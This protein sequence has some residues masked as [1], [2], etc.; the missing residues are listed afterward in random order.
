M[1]IRRITVSR[2]ESGRTVAALLQAHFQLSA[3]EVRRLVQARRVRIGGKVCADPAWR[4]APGQSLKA[5]LDPSPPHA[6]SQTKAARHREEQGTPPTVRH[7][8]DRLVIVDKPAGLTTMRHEYEAEE[9]GPRGRRFLPATLADLLPDLLPKGRQGRAARVI[10][11]HRL[12]RE[13]SG[14][15]AFAR[16]PEAARHLGA[17]FREHT[18][19]RTYLALTRG[20]P[21][22]GRVESRIVRDRGDGRRGSTEKPGEGQRAVTHV[23]VVEELGDFALVECRLETGR[24]HQVRIH[25]G[26][27]GAP[28]CGERVYDR[29]PH[30]RPLPDASGAKRPTLHAATL[31]LEHPTTGERMTWEAPLPADMARLLKQLRRK[32]RH[33]EGEGGRG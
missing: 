17:Q 26:E 22:P 28:L 4:V 21:R 13:T 20:I 2:T 30:G 29:P 6:R 5:E 31:G 23:Y 15:V 12:D 10:P 25:L 1:P 11:V 9:F 19:E 8:D 14:L 24:T 27:L 3:A 18:I 33:A 16:T 32:A 7:A